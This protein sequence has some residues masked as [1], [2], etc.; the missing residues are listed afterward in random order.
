MQ[1]FAMPA[2]SNRK[3]NPYCALLYEAMARQGTDVREFSRI[4]LLRGRPDVWHMHWPEGTL[5]EPGCM[6]TVARV[7]LLFAFLGLAKLKGIKRIW[8]MHNL[9]THEQP[10]PWIE[11]WFWRWFPRCLDGCISLSE[12]GRKMALER[13]EAL[14]N[15]PVFVVPHGHYRGV[16]ADTIS[17]LEARRR[18]GIAPDSP[19]VAFFGLIR[20]YK[21]VPLLIRTFRQLEDSRATLCIAGKPDTTELAREIETAV[22]DDLRIKVVAGFIPDDDVQLYLRAADLAVLPFAEILNSGSSLLALSFDCPVLIPNK[23]AMDELARRVGKDWVQTYDGDLNVQI[24]DQALRWALDMRRAPRAPL[25]QFDWAQVAGQ[26]MDAYEQICGGP[27]D[28][29]Q[30]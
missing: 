6:R 1:V 14:C 5:I 21:N 25:E 18:L 13:F 7:T 16:Y 20:P 12:T 19:M 22:G 28:P 17:R 11:R 15:K 27:R 8:T 9:H 29:K 26:T 30:P 3:F 10:H 2:F 4:R 23:G 24:L